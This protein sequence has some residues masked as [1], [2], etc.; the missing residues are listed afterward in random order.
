MNGKWRLA[1]ADQSHSGSQLGASN[2]GELGPWV[3]APA[4]RSGGE[5]PECGEGAP[6]MST[7]APTSRVVYVYSVY[8]DTSLPLNLYPI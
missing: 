1:E 7:Y 4:N 3:K 8:F 5:A 6:E 2:C